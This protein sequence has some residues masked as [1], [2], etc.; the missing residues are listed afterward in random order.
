VAVEKVDPIDANSAVWPPGHGGQ[1]DMGATTEGNL[2][3]DGSIDFLAGTAA[4]LH[5][6]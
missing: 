1:V 5:A 6:R 4:L 3:I 2:V